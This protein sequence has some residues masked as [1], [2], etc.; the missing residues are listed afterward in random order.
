MPGVDRFR[1]T[2]QWDLVG[3]R[4]IELLHFGFKPR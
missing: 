2:L 4:S 1:H 3:R